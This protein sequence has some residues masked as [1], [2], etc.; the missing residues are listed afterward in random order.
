MWRRLSGPD[1]GI[2]F[3]LYKSTIASVFKCPE[4]WVVQSDLLDLTNPFSTQK[5]AKQ[6]VEASYGVLCETHRRRMDKKPED[7]LPDHEDKSEGFL[8][9]ILKE[10]KE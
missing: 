5:E 3:C 8:D 7:L 9:D 1:K 10:F 4:G 2:R 6:A